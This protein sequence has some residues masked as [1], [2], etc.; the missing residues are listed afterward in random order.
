MAITAPLVW[1]DGAL[2]PAADATLPLMGHAPQ[3]G[4]LVFDVGS[5]HP[6]TKGPALFRAREHVARFV[7]SARI[8]GLSLAY[9]EEALVRAAVSVVRE[10]RRDEGLVRWSVF[11]AAAEPD[12]LPRDGA[13]RVAVA[14]QLLQDTGR[15]KPLRI[16]VFDDARKASPDVLSPEAK[17]AASY[18]G[19]MI[20]RRRA[21]ASGADDV[22]LL[23]RDGDVAEAPIANVFVVRGG[24]LVTPSLGYVL[25]G[26]T[27]DAVLA[28]ARDEGLS[29]Q[30]AKLS[31]EALATADEA[32]LTATSLPIAPV[33]SVNGRALASAPGPITARLVERFEAAQRGAHPSFAHWLTHLG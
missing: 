4:S 25:P 33:A 16:A 30:E 21:V 19:P 7:N 3:R 5:F 6:T 15:P 32:F 23:D 24:T 2:V 1:L 29:V 11:F 26:I 22:V 13:T 9:D 18:L 27:R 28:I 17:A 8:V 14:A 12:L 20:A 10:C 31:P